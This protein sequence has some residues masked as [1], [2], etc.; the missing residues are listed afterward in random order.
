MEE[1]KI[2]PVYDNYLCMKGDFGGISYYMTTLPIDKVAD[3]LHFEK[4]LNI[5]NASFAERVQRT[6]NQKRAEEEI[7][8]KYLLNEGTRFFNSLVVTIIPDNEDKG[9]YKETCKGANIYELSLSQNVKKIVVD[10]QHRLFALRKLRE[11]IIGGRLDN[12]EDLKKLQVP[13]IFV[14]FNKVDSKIEN[15]N[16]IKDDII[17]ETRRVFTALN[18][19]AKKID[20]YTTLILDDSDFSA[21]VSRKILEDKLVDELYVKWAYS[22]TALNQYDVFFTTLN[23]I[24][25]MVES[26]CKKLN[27]SL[28]DEDLSTDDKSKELIVQYF[29]QNVDEIGVSPKELI[30]NFFEL[31][32]FKEWK[33][34]LKNSGIQLEKQPIET[35][36]SKEQKDSI[37]D[38]RN[39]NILAQVIGQKALFNAIVHEDTLSRLGET[40]KEKIKEVYTRIEKLITIG[41]MKKSNDIWKGILVG[42]DKQGKMIAKQQNV[43]FASLILSLLLTYD[44]YN[45]NDLEA[46]K[47]NINKMLSDKLGVINKINKINEIIEE[48]R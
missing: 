35:K 39:K 3:S 48:L 29:E 45:K 21:V 24:N 27:K 11:D 13:I 17:K 28:D 6:L 10:G 15:Q 14:L 46:K 5:E 22:S 9:F 16:P 44:K 30:T 2:E 7:Y 34:E 40:P 25:D 20:K 1:L 33:L 47:E 42:E 4:D 32:F 8:Q 37:K 18:K 12:R 23:I 41:V 19:T 38:L 31:S 43:D 26:Y 36:L